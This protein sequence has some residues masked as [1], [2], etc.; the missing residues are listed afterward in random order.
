MILNHTGTQI[1]KHS[2]IC[3]VYVEIR[4]AWNPSDHH[5]KLGQALVVSALALLSIV[6]S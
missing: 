4:F 1:Y 2:I 3:M 5:S 6:D